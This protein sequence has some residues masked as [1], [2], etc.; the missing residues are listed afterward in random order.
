MPHHFLHTPFGEVHYRKLGGGPRLLIALHGFGADSSYFQCLGP[1]LHGICTLYAIDLPFHGLTRW[2]EPGFRPGH[3]EHIVRAILQ[4][5]GRERFEAVGHSLG[6]RLWLCLLDRLGG[7]MD[8]LYLL[9]P[10]G[11]QTRWMGLAGRLP[12]FLRRLVGRLA[13]Q[14]EKGL[15][16]A[17]QLQHR[18]LIDGFVVRYL[19]HHLKNSDRR[20]RLLNTWYALSNFPLNTGSAR[21]LLSTLRAPVLVLLGKQDILAPAAALRMALDGLP[22]VEVREVDANHRTVC[23]WVVPFL[24]DGLRAAENAFAARPR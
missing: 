9:A 20:R 3:I 13:A 19:K 5:E 24:K 18:G 4:C 22:N 14:P 21:S 12:L 1:S 17:Q 23:Q 6:G 10:D 7:Q 15:A 16:L 2:K 11:L 8:A